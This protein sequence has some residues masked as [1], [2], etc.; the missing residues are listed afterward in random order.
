MAKEANVLEFTFEK[1][2]FSV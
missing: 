1:T 2:G